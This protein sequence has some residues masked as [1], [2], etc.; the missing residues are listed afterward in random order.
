MTESLR[1]FVASS[2]EQIAVARTVAEALRSPRLEPKVW[3]EETFEFSD[4]YIESL[5]DELERADLAV[6]ILTADDSANVRSKAVNLP[7][8]N[9]IFELGLFTGRLGRKRCFFL[10]DAEASTQVAS[11]LSGVNAVT[12]H[13]D[14]T[15]E[16]PGRRSLAAQLK[17]LQRQLLQHEVRYKPSQETRRGQE[18][19]WHFSR[20]LA[21]HWWERMRVGEDDKSAL[22]YVTITIDEVTNNPSFQGWAY[23]RDGEPMADWNSVVAGAILGAEPIIHYHWEG[24]HDAQTGQKF[25][26]GGLIRFDTGALKSASGYFYDTNFAM[27]SQGAPTLVKHFGLY[28]CESSDDETMRERWSEAA[29]QLVRDR[30][31]GLVGR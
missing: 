2:A 14:G 28:R 8:D 21:G 23:D 27:A 25:G 1:V 30:L 10:L 7:R 31:E 3:D 24:E 15:S 18:A 4:S 20:Q 16:D 12:F 5:E 11:D 26:G 17:R 9:V 22:S 29:R 6:V 19:L 13:R